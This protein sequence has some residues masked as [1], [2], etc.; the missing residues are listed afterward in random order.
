MKVDY[1]A[2]KDTALDWAVAKAEGLSLEFDPMGF[3]HDA[4]GSI[5]AGW[6]VDD[7]IVGHHKTNPNQHKGYSPSTDFAQGGPIIEREKID[8]FTE[9]GTLE[10]WCASAARH[11]NGQRLVGW[12]LHA[13]GPT[14]LI[15]AM[16]CYVVSKLGGRIEIPDKLMFDC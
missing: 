14:P 15:A 12:R 5:L 3:R 8:L 7:M 11:Q 13:Y 1:F 2:L 10:S 4:P 9:K 6:W 16:R